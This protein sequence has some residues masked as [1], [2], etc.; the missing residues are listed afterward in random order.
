MLRNIFIS[1]ES[2]Q[3]ECVFCNDFHA[4]A[5]D[6]QA[7]IGYTAHKLSPRALI[8][9]VLAKIQELNDNDQA[10][11]ILI[12]RP[13]PEHLSEHEVMNSVAPYKHIEELS[14]GKRNNIAVDG[15]SRL[16]NSYGKAWMLELNIILLGGTNIITSGFKAE[17]AR[18]HKHVQVVPTLESAT[19]DP[20]HDTIIITELNKGGVIKPE[21]LGPAIRLIVDLGFDVD[22]KAGDLDADILDMEDLLVVPTPGGVLPVLLWIMMERTINARDDQL[23][24][25]NLLCLPSCSVV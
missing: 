20:K 1:R 15:L 25:S 8:E 13:V 22:T 18:K 12:Q 23:G 4:S 16:L 6:D 11:G 5:D 24:R 9:K 3:N 17:L 21:M 19:M 10:H 14:R 7:G 2:L